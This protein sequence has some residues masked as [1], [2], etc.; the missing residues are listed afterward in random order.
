MFLFYFILETGGMDR[1]EYHATH[2][3]I[4]RNVLAT[5]RASAEANLFVYNYSTYKA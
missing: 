4:T 5:T 2:T 3:R 1:L